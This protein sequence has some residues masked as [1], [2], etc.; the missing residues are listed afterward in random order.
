MLTFFDF[1]QTS[2]SEFNYC[3]VISSLSKYKAGSYFSER[4]EVKRR[5]QE[6]GGK[7]RHLNWKK[8]FLRLNT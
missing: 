1:F 2:W 4:T 3:F 8:G 7:P 6:T 5:K